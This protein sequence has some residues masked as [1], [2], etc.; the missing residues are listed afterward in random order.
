MD[1]TQAQLSWQ[2]PPAQAQTE[3]GNGGLPIKDYVVE[4]HMEGDVDASGADRWTVVP[5]KEASTKTRWTVEGLD[6]AKHY[7]FRVSAWNEAG[8]GDWLRLENQRTI[9]MADDSAEFGLGAPSVKVDV[10]DNDVLLSDPSAVPP[11]EEEPVDAETAKTLKILDPRDDAPK[12]YT[13][14]LTV[15]GEGTYTVEH[16]AI[17]FTPARA[18]D[19]EGPLTPITYALGLE[20]CRSHAK[21]RLTAQP[22][23]IALEKS[24]KLA[25]GAAGAVGDRID[26]SFTMKNTGFSTLLGVSLGDQLTGMSDFAYEWP[27][28]AKPGELAPGEEATATAHSA[29]TAEQRSA[30]FVVNS[31]VVTGVAGD[32]EVKA[33]AT[34][35]V[36]LPDPPEPTA[37]PTTEPTA[38]TTP[39]TPT[40]D[41]TPPTT[42][43]T[44]P[45][46]PPTVDPTADPTSE[47]TV[48]P[49][50]GP[51]TA[52][53]GTP[54]TGPAPTSGPT[55]GVPSP[56]ASSAPS[57]SRPTTQP[58]AP[59]SSSPG[60]PGN[61]P[62]PGPNGPPDDR[63]PLPRTGVQG[64]ASALVAA[65][66][67]I[68]GGVLTAVRARRRR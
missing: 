11:L 4:Q 21:L 23:S 30:G 16:G 62:A 3:A 24:G 17:V 61:P 12:K 51:T 39:P 20:G 33:E 1:R 49:T 41:P 40:I 35:R 31:A 22:N 43:P 27:D 65:G 7:D 2:A 46:T 8:N 54:T 28:P 32:R 9:R 53:T 13:D 34:A 42:E 25:V 44:K 66:C 64:I 59:A 36:E 45:S 37:S 14:S 15:D 68:V 58:P 50:P 29:V 26:W 47:P 18:F 52:P 55:S 63:S 19:T 38:P 67:L 6:P 10:L 57:T 56:S 48:D 5:K 60:D